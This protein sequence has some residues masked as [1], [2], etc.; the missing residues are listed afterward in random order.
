MTSC[1]ATG[2]E[3][4]STAKRTAGAIRIGAM[5]FLLPHSHMH[6]D[7]QHLIHLQDLVLGIDRLRKRIDEIP[8]A[9]QALDA[10]LATHTAT[11]EAVKKRVADNQAARRDIDK[12]LAELNA[13]LSKFKNQLMEVKTN[14]EYQAMQKEMGH[15]QDE[16]G[17]H[18]THML[19]KMEETDGLTAELRTAEAAL[20]KGQAEIAAERTKLDTER[21]TDQQEL[22]RLV[23]E[24]DQV[25]GQISPEAMK[26]FERVSHGRKGIAVA[27]AR[28]GLCVVC[29]VRLRPQVFNEVR[30]NDQL[31]QC[32]S[33]TRILYHVPAAPAPVPQP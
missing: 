29:H 20:K 13:R 2:S 23:S 15:A 4:M 14:K 7:L 12:H 33:C 8:S 3:G 1:E 18:E 19:E 9:Q 17:T 6:P 32:D 26:I 22:E 21:A 10:R 24:R 28:D 11:L 30:R 16:I 25:A 31:I 27:E 5:I